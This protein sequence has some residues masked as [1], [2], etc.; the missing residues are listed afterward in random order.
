MYQLR[1]RQ[2]WGEE[3]E[4]A[5][6]GE[7]ESKRREAKLMR[8]D[9]VLIANCREKACFDRCPQMGGKQNSDDLIN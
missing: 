5:R 6:E 8:G 3:E 9:S 2:R 4:R 7:G 1:L